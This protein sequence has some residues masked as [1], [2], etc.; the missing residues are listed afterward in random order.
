[1]K[2]ETKE[3]RTP[4]AHWTLF[5]RFRDDGPEHEFCAT[6][7][8][9]GSCG[10][11]AAVLPA[12]GQGYER[13]MVSSVVARGALMQSFYRRWTGDRFVIPEEFREEL[14]AKVWL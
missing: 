9:D 5:V 8:C 7:L 3:P 13:R 6:P 11:P 14:I 2:I 12:V 10:F 1:M 4:G